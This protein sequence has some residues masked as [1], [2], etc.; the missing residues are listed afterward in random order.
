MLSWS[1]SLATQLAFGGWGMGV[2]VEI[3]GVGMRG[4]CT[5]EIFPNVAISYPVTRGLCLQG[6]LSL[7]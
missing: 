1:V 5:S 6:P 3:G 4:H 2:G 7:L